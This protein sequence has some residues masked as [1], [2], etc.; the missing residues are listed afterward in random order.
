MLKRLRSSLFF[1]IY[2]TL[3]AC[4][5]AVAIMSAVFVR[6]GQDQEDRSWQGRLDAFLT[7][8][9]PE[10]ASRDDLQARLDWLSDAFDTDIGLYAQNGRPI[11]S[12]GN[13]PLPEHTPFW[14]NRRNDDDRRGFAFRLEDGRI[15]T[16]NIAGHLRPGVRSPLLYM[17]LIAAVIGLASY[18]V[19]RHLTRRL[20]RLRQ[21]VETWGDGAKLARV[22]LPGTDEVAAVAISFNAAADRIEALIASHRA[23]LANASHELRSPLARLRMA[24]DIYE[25][26]PSEAVKR[27]IV[28]N[29]AELDDLVG[30][31][32]LAS[33]LDHV[34][35]LDS[36]EEF[37]LLALTS[38][39][40]A[41]HDIKVDGEAAAVN[42]DPKLLT[43]LIRNL[44]LNAKRHGS[45]PVT[46]SLSIHGPMAVLAVTDS[47]TGIAETDRARIFEPFYR[48]RG[49]GEQAGGWGLGL[50]LVRQ[51]A[52]HHGGSVRYDAPAGGGSRFTVLLPLSGGVKPQMA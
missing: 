35:D 9:L 1:K 14:R 18:P 29:L 12:A 24:I 34:E 26:A 49:Y 40:A 28:Q 8:T 51:I 43:R 44:I 31:I 5:A 3:L 39:E 13:P 15:V 41:R 36:R 38:E 6:A 25:S 19:V 50:S 47:G 30:E 52:E 42:G 20:E 11:A 4:L 2:V 17:A 16:A 27:E 21:G 32:L 7:A 33:R 45:E 10:T 37:D 23:L 46:V 48:P 22:E